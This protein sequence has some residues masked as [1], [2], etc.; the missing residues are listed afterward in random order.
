M[1]IVLEIRAQPSLHLQPRTLLGTEGGSGHWA[2]TGEG[3]YQG[4]QQ[5]E[6]GEWVAGVSKSI[7]WRPRGQWRKHYTW[8]GTPS[9][10]H[11]LYCPLDLTEKRLKDKIRKN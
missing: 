10:R 2:G 4:D 6:V 7:S 8:A 5:P 3:G 1:F 11:I 9:L